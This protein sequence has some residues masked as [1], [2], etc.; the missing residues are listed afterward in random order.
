MNHAANR[1][2]AGD[3]TA[4]K[5]YENSDFRD[6]ANLRP[7]DWIIVNGCPKDE[8]LTTG[9]D[10]TKNRNADPWENISV[11]VRRDRVERELPS[12]NSIR[13]AIPV[14]CMSRGETVWTESETRW[15]NNIGIPRDAT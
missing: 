10:A 3:E 11:A 1:R 8:F 5:Y 12:P 9:N 2:G 7:C 14:R 15:L 4:S 6:G 13:S